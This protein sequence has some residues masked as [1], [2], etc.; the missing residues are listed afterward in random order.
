MDIELRAVVPAAILALNELRRI[1][2]IDALPIFAEREK[3]RLA[4][5]PLPLAPACLTMIS[6]ITATPNQLA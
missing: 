3:S 1:R 5:T 6:V 2:Q 4:N